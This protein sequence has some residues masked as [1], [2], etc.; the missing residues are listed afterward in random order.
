MKPLRRDARS[1][2][3]EQTSY[4]PKIPHV[5]CLRVANKLTTAVRGLERAD[6]ISVECNG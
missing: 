3:W 1:A 6:N 5:N 4:A 2:Q